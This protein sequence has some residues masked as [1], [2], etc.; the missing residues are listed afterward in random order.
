[1]LFDG[2]CR[3]ES[4]LSEHPG[5]SL[6]VYHFGLVFHARLRPL[7][8]QRPLIRELRGLRAVRRGSGTNSR[9]EFGLVPDSNCFICFGEVAMRGVIVHVSLTA[10]TDALGVGLTE[11]LSDRIDRC[12]NLDLDFVHTPTLIG[13]LI[14]AV[15][16]LIQR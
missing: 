15:D 5:R 4:E 6:A 14:R 16:A 13:T 11:S 8:D 7:I 9:D 10:S 2:R 3:L 1:M 12:G